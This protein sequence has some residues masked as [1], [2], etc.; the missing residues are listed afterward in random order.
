[1]AEPRRL[2]PGGGPAEQLTALSRDAE[3]TARRLAQVEALVRELAA[4]VTELAARLDDRDTCRPRSWLAPAGEQAAADL[5][6]D[7]AAW[8]RR[9]YLHYPGAGL[10]SCWLWHPAAVEELLWLRHAHHDAYDGPRAGWQRVADW[11]DRLRPAVVRRI[12]EAISSCE[13]LCHTPGHDLDRPPAAVP[14]PAAVDAIA[15]WAG[16]GLDTPPPTP[17][18]TQL[19]DAEHTD[20]ATRRRRPDPQTPRTSP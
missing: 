12:G 9:V 13:L 1:V 8:L 20:R 2:V 3:R 19:T 4:A 6:T 7:L 18:P 17:T 10:P 5:L 11:H 16:R 15:H 14:L